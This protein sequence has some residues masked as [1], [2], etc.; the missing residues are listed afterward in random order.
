MSLIDKSDK[1][2]SYPHLD[3]DAFQELIEELCLASEQDISYLLDHIEKHYEFEFPLW[4]RLL[5]YRLALLQ[6]PDNPDLLERAG[7]GILLYADPF[8]DDIAKGY[9]RKAKEIRDRQYSL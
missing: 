8:Y 2:M 9:I 5:C 1:L 3:T 7:Q 4:A 6:A